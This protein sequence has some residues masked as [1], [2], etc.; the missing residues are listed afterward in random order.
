MPIYK[1]KGTKKYKVRVN[2]VDTDGNYKAKYATTNTYEEAV[3][4]YNELYENRL[5]QDN[6]TLQKLVE[7]Y[8]MVVK[9][10][11]KLI[12]YKNYRQY[13]K[14]ILAFS[15][16]KIRI[17]DITPLYIRNWQNALVDHGY[18]PKTVY[19]YNSTFSALMNFAKTFYGLKTNPV[20]LA[21]KIGKAYTTE[22]KFYTLQE[23][24]QFVSAIDRKKYLS[25]W[26]LFNLLFYGGCRIGEALALFPEDINFEEET[27]SITKTYHELNAQAYLSVPK[28]KNANRKIKIPHYLTLILNDYIKKLPA[29]GLRL[30]FS[31][32]FSKLYE[33]N[34]RAAKTANLKVIRIHDFRHSA[35]SFLIS[36]NVPILEISKRVG[37]SS[38]DITY[39]VYAHLYP[40]KDRH[41]AQ[42]EDEDFKNWGL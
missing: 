8:L 10:K 27:I 40:N 12:T 4:K 2:Y 5:V 23:F 17:K 39:S 38:P 31:V 30:F 1:V 36:Q 35:V 9:V 18:T 21:G 22:R 28:T 33:I 37:H 16:P 7:E 26:V 25:Y 19:V 14:A 29:P 41:I 15:D 13:F 6:V 11:D 20:K 34:R 3:L 42:K 24:N 32:E